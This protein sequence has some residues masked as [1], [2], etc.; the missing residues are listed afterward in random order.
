MVIF[1]ILLYLNF[2]IMKKILLLLFIFLILVTWEANANW[3]IS[4]VNTAYNTSSKIAWTVCAWNG[5]AYETIPHVT[6]CFNSNWWTTPLWDNLPGWDNLSAVS[7][8]SPSPYNWDPASHTDSILG[9]AQGW[10]AS[11][12]YWDSQNPTI[13]NSLA[14]EGND[15]AWISWS[16]KTVTLTPAD[17]WWS[18]VGVTK[19]CEWSTCNP[20]TWNVWT[21]I[22]K[23]ANYNNTIRYQIWDNSLNASA[24]WSFVLKLDNT[25]PTV[26]NDYAY[27]NIWVNWLSKTITLSPSDTWW[28]WVN[29]TKWCEWSTCNPSTW[30]VWTVITK[31]ADY[32]NT[33]RYQ[34]WDIAWNSSAIGSFVLKLDNTKPSPSDLPDA[35]SNPANNSNFLATNWQTFTITPLDN[36]WSPIVKVQWFFEDSTSCADLFHPRI[37]SNS[38][39]ISTTAATHNIKEVKPGCDFDAWWYRQYSFKITYIEDSAWNFLWT[40]NAAS[41]NVWIKTFNYK[42]F[43]S[44]LAAN[45][46][47][48][49]VTTDQVTDTNNIADWVQK[50]IVVTLS[51]NFWN[52]IIPASFIW[53]NISF[54]FDVNNNLYLNQYDNSWWS[55][56][57]MSI[58]SD[59]LNFLNTRFSTWTGQIATF[60]NQ[61]SSDWTYLFWNKVFAPTNYV[62][63]GNDFTINSIKF[64]IIR[65]ISILIWDNPI[66]QLVSN[67]SKIFSF[68]PIYETLLSWEIATSWFVEWTM[69]S[70]YIDINKNWVS[71]TSS[72]LLS[73]VQT[74][75]TSNYFSWSWNIDSNPIKTIFKTWIWTQFILDPFNIS[76]NYIF[77]TLFTLVD[78]SWYTNDI[79][80][81]RLNEYIKYSIWG[82]MVTY[83]AWIL[84]NSNSQNFE[85]LKIYWITNINKSKQKDLVYNQDI[86]NIQNL[87]WVINKSILKRD[88]RKNATSTFKSIVVSN[89]TNT[90]SDLSWANWINT[91]WSKLWN[92][93]YFWALNWW[94]VVL[95]DS[96]HKFVW[97]KT[98]VLN[99]WN[100]YIKSNIINNLNS[101][102][103]WIIVLKDENN[104][105][106][107]VYIDS[108]V[109]EIDAVIYSDKSVMSYSEFYDNGS[110][111]TIVKH[112]LD[113]NVSNSWL[114]NQLYIYWTIFSENTIWWSRKNPPVCPF[115]VKSDNS[116]TCDIVEAQ[117]YDLNYL[118]AWVNNKYNSAY[119]NYPIVIKYNSTMQSTPPPL[120][121]K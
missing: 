120:F 87:A 37:D 7:W 30:N 18:W 32:N 81:I 105:W 88:I 73:F 35:S 4:W 103:L 85:T 10:N 95:N 86:Q 24:I 34:T 67:S 108:S 69:Q 2:L 72:D 23:S 92:I 27:S 51:D 98:I 77:N 48:K 53:R 57:F 79:K 107:K 41:N 1:I 96:I 118:R 28:S 14:S 42:V 93:L 52:P 56:V 44:T 110:S 11:C 80:D 89:W 12:F 115:Y 39:S 117:K 94:N 36:G 63:P 38:S 21:S 76:I 9:V 58:P 31:N 19:W 47:T 111:D 59:S 113:W 91:D 43:A 101:D 83:L 82:K 78:W 112:E 119:P 106:W 61:I 60:S 5:C 3:Y 6:N 84:N 22:T 46:T 33:I 104:K 55:A 16:S 75:T 40:L 8:T 71:T 66:N 97:R 45:I 26:T 100:L 49:S 25:I 116:L 65:T 20:S 121:S 74:W 109:Q 70:W 54:T 50:D 64:S 62:V 114:K 102:I 68:K 17:T 90:I 13:S 15:G 29:V 99:W